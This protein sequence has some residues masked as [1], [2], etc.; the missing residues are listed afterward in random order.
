MEFLVGSTGL[1]VVRVTLVL[2]YNVAMYCL[3]VKGIS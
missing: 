2:L 3:R 1:A